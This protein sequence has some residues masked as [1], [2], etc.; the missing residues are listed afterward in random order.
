[1]AT[2]PIALPSPSCGISAPTRWIAQLPRVAT[3]ASER[4]L[5][6][7]RDQQEIALFAEGKEKRPEPFRLHLCACAGA[8]AAPA[9]AC[10]ALRAAMLPR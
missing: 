8:G 3:Q 7:M 5:R 9:C 6:P 10:A 1:M 2:L 4:A